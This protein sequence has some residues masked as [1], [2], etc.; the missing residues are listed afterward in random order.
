MSPRVPSGLTLG[1]VEALI[2]T[3]VGLLGFILGIVIWWRIF[4]KAGYSGLLGLLMFV[5][6][7]NV[8]VLLYFAFG[9]WPIEKEVERLRGS[10]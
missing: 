1:A 10:R 4:S 5:P 8:I 9:T 7:V 3:V 6:L 2:V